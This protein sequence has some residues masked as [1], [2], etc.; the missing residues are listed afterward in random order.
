MNDTKPTSSSLLK[1]LLL[2]CLALLAFAA[3]SVFC[4]LALGSDSID[5]TS[6]TVIRLLSGAIVLTLLLVLK[7]QHKA[8]SHGGSWKGASMLF[9]Y[10]GCFSFAYRFLDTGT[11]ALILFGSVQLTMLG[12]AL[13]AGNRFNRFEWLGICSALGGFI[14]LFLPSATTPSLQG[15]VLMAIAGIA[16]GVYTLL[17]RE[18]KTPLADTCHNFVRSLPFCVLLGIV[19]IG[20]S[21]LSSHGIVLAMLSGG[22][23]SGIGYSIWYTALRGLSSSSAAVLQLLVPVIAA[24]GGVI[25]VGEELTLSL[26]VSATLILGGVALVIAGRTLLK[27]ATD[28]SP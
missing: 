26:A 19:F 23:A 7:G 27:T 10:A 24:I 1:T 17:G 16:W 5:A 3:N 14:Y 11:G 2:T 18:S 6:F 15:F 22:L 9:L 8:P 21:D 12:L 20:Q 13:L 25:F 4:R 28:K